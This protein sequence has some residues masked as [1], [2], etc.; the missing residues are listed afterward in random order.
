MFRILRNDERHD[1]YK[2]PKIVQIAKSEKLHWVGHCKLASTQNTVAVTSWKY[3][4]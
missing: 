2:S 1:F 3:L 4:A